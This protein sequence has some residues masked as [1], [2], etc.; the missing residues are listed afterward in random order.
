[1]CC[2]ARDYYDLL[3]LPRSAK[4]DEIYKRFRE[5]A[6]KTHPKIVQ[7][8]SETDYKILRYFID[9]CRSL[10][11]LSDDKLRQVY[12]QYGE[13][14]LR[15]IL[16][17]EYH[18]DYERTFKNFFGSNNPYVSIKRVKVVRK[19][20]DDTRESLIDENKIVKVKLNRGTRSGSLFLFPNLGNQDLNGRSGRLVLRVQI[21]NTS[22]FLVEG[23]DLVHKCDI[24]LK[25][26][27]AGFV[28][29]IVT[30]SGRSYKIRP[31]RLVEPKSQYSIV[32]NSLPMKNSSARILSIDMQL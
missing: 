18:G 22:Q 25:E 3:G 28:R 12:D 17:Y 9:L 2:A 1:M 8:S 21:A 31:N 20:L 7:N 5:L 19:V 4:L 27:L 29:D 26:S 15:K 10:E 30:V 14:G 32:T 13:V 24:T 11:V 16:K 6:L 23:N